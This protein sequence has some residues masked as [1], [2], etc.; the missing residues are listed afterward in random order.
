MALQ[1]AVPKHSRKQAKC[2]QFHLRYL[3]KRKLSGSHI[4]LLEFPF[5][6]VKPVGFLNDVVY[7]GI[8]YQMRATFVIGILKYGKYIHEC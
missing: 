2:E 8:G 4:R 6:S 7:V 1:L 5:E 3:C